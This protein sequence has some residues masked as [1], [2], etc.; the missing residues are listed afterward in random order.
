MRSMGIAAEKIAIHK[1]KLAEGTT[2]ICNG[3]GYTTREGVPQ[4]CPVCKQIREQFSKIDQE[5]LSSLV[6]L[7]GGLEE[8]TTFDGVK[9]RWTDEAKKLLRTVPSGYERRRAKA[10]M[11]KLART[12]RLGMITK[13]IAQEIAGADRNPVAAAADAT[14]IPAAESEATMTWTPDAK[15]R[16]ARVPAGFMRNMT[17]DRIESLAKEKGLEIVSLDT[18]EEAIG[19]ARQTMHDTIGAYMQNTEAMRQSMRET[20]EN[21]GD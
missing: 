21:A 6:P 4:I 3:C 18:A 5:T 11:E 16:L 13:E 2:Y 12:K 9:L 14:S 7:E 19:M 1:Q 8:E 15:Q 17:R 20:A 10:R